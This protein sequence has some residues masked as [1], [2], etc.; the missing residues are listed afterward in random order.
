MARQLSAVATALAATACLSACGQKA[1][2][3][4]LTDVC[5][6][7]FGGNSEMCSCWVDS[8]EG[9]LSPDQFAEL[10]Q[11]IYDNRRFSGDWI[12]GPIRSDQD[13]RL[14]IAD[15]TGACIAGG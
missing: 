11:A 13:F 14:P 2:K 7:K 5:L 1:G 4:E 6:D 12:P 3:T 15:A 9:A 10:S 8:V